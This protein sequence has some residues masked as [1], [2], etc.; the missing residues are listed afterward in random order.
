[1]KSV[2]HTAIE[3]VAARSPDRIAIRAPEG[4]IS[5]SGL[6][7]AARRLAVQLRRDHGLQPGAIVAL[8]LP[9]GIAYLTAVLAVAKAG[10]VFLPIE[11][12]MPLRRRQACVTRARPVVVIADGTGAVAWQ[13]GDHQVPILR[14]DGVAPDDAPALPLCVTGD[15][16]SYIMFTSGS[17][18]EPKAILGTHKGLSHFVHWEVREFGL[19]PDD[20][21][22]QLAPLT[23]DV[24]LRDVFVPLLAGGTLCVAAAETRQS[25]RTLLDWLQ[26][27]AITLM[28]CV[29]SLFRALIEEIDSRPA[30]VLPALRRVLLAGEPLYGRDVQRWRAVMGERVELVN[31]YGPSETTLAKAFHR[32]ADIPVETA[33]MIPVGLP[34]P[35]TALLIVRDGELCDKGEIG[36]VFI[37]TPFMSRG[38]LND[39][40]S[41][42]QA[43]VQNPLTPDTPDLIYRT[44]D[45]GR[46]RADRSVELLGRRDAQVKV[47][48]V[49]IELGDVE[50][51]LLQHLSIRQAVVADHTGGD[52]QVLLCAYFIADTHLADESLREH[53]RQWLDVAMHPAFFVQME[54]LPL[55]LHGKVN[56]RALPRPAELLYRERACIEPE[57]EHEIA[58]AAI[59]SDILGVSKIG[60]THRFVE[61]GGDSLKAIRALSRIVQ[62]SGVEVKL[63][64][65]FP[66]GTVREVAGLIAA[67][68]ASGTDSGHSEAASAIVPVIEPPTAE[69]LQWLEQ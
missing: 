13:A 64:E 65:L 44:G 17:T 45:M 46:Y 15:D 27:E 30:G 19:G 59:W 43:F 11:L 60:V 26:A 58:V 41:T 53:M 35:N 66:R 34:L 10:G 28:H 22:A 54:A 14:I 8:F 7:S 47:N 56:R 4:T 62:H 38:Y 69:E 18:G 63:Q 61:L 16:P 31:L 12:G 55:N 24:S 50:Q 52:Q 33:R 29:P 1:M 6:D 21:I 20:R 57:G 9:P 67:R 23:F 5:Y 3:E 42:Q 25:T 32:I 40:Q 39:P 36:E 37:K 2:L 51:A 49:R 48:G 68:Q